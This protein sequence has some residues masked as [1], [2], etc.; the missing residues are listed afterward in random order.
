MVQ[1]PGIGPQQ[2]LPGWRA[3]GKCLAFSLR[4]KNTPR[5]GFEGV[6]YKT[7]FTS[8]A[9]VSWFFIIRKASFRYTQF[10]MRRFLEGIIALEKFGVY[11][12]LASTIH[13]VVPVLQVPWSWSSSSVCFGVWPG[14][15]NGLAFR[16]RPFY[17]LCWD[18]M[19]P[20]GRQAVTPRLPASVKRRANRVG[21][22]STCM[23]WPNATYI[24]S[25]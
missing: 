7:L 13:A 9:T 1:S 24:V 6:G 18:A 12:V 5:L 4:V 15:E 22:V 19:R 17:W 16:N 2:T 20:Y 14:L 8:E 10:R 21:V 11:G 3:A 23:S 25:I